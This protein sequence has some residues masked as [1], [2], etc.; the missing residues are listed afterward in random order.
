GD[1][2]RLQRAL[3]GQYGSAQ[4]AGL[5]HWLGL[6]LAACCASNGQLE[7]AHGLLAA[8]TADSGTLGLRALE[9]R[10]RLGRSGGPA[11]WTLEAL[12]LQAAR[13]LVSSSPGRNR[14]SACAPGRALA[15]LLELAR[16]QSDLGHEEEAADT[17]ERAL[18]IDPDDA[19][20][21]HALLRQAERAGRH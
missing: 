14:S 9:S 11:E 18:E 17:L 2:A 5:S 15:A 8:A 20:A 21:A 7:R 12:A 16:L 10:G 19:V 1:G 13:I 6:E 4:D 3:E